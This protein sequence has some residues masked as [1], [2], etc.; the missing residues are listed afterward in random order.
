MLFHRLTQIVCL[1]QKLT[2][3]GIR[4]GRQDTWKACIVVQLIYMLHTW[5]NVRPTAVLKP[6]SIYITT[7]G[8]SLSSLSKFSSFF[9]SAKGLIFSHSPAVVNII[10]NVILVFETL[11]SS[12][13][14]SISNSGGETLLQL[15]NLSGSMVLNMDEFS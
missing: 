11:I 9:G 6:L 2:G 10:L 3:A 5:P 8:S 15:I 7:F 14:T 1:R 4:R 12:N 13:P